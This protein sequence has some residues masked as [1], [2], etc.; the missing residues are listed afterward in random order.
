MLSSGIQ[1]K[2]EHCGQQEIFS[3][4]LQSAP[5]LCEHQEVHPVSQQLYHHLMPQ[6]EHSQEFGEHTLKRLVWI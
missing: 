3:N 2:G 4:D 1:T 6:E 5:L